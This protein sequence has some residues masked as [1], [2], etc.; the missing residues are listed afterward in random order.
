MV[1]DSK[2]ERLHKQKIRLDAIEDKLNNEI[3]KAEDELKYFL[4]AKAAYHLL[5]TLTLWKMVP[6][7]KANMTQVYNYAW[8][9]NVKENKK[10][11]AETASNSHA[12]DL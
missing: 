4:K 2:Q 8:R 1:L 3:A 12:H 6:L 9:M 7:V 10:E 11:A 5:S